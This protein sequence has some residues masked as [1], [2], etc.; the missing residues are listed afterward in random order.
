MNLLK[1]K[2]P[3]RVPENPD[4]YYHGFVRDLGKIDSEYYEQNVLYLLPPKWKSGLQ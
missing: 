2:R 4:R 1:K 3:G